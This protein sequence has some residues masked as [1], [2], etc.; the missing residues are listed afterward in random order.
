MTIV[1]AIILVVG[2]I[3]II[4]I[5]DLVGKSKKVIDVAKHSADVFQNPDMSDLEKEKAMQKNS[6]ILFKYFFIIVAVCAIAVFA[7]LGVIWLVQLTGV[8]TV[9]NVLHATFS[10]QFIVISSIFIIGI[11]WLLR[12]KNV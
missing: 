2:F 7:P 11:T 12:R 9:E 3:A 6:I 5:F 1:G 4:N 10:W 8:T